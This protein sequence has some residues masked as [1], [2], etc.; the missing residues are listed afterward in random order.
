MK[1]ILYGIC[2]I[3][4]GHVFRQLPRILGYLENNATVAVLCYGRS[5]DVLYEYQARHKNLYLF[6]VEIPYIPG[7]S[8][9]LDFIGASALANPEG[10][11]INFEAMSKVSDLIG[12]PDIVFSDYEPFSAS[13]AYAYDSPLITIDQQSKYLFETCPETLNNT[14]YLDEVMRLR[15]FFPKAS[16]RIACSFFKIDR[17]AKYPEL[18]IV[19]APVRETLRHE[20]LIKPK[21]NNF[22][23]YLSE[24]YL[25]QDF[26]EKLGDTLSVH[27]NSIFHVY[28]PK[29]II[30]R[31]NTKNVNYFYHGD[32]S[33]ESRFL[34]SCGVIS[35]AGH[36]LLSECVYLHKPVL[37]IP[38]SIYEQQMNA[39]VIEHAGV[40]IR[41]NMI[42][43]DVITEFTT[44]INTF[45]KNYDGNDWFK[46]P[47]LSEEL[48]LGVI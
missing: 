43:S 35:T 7:S 39:F 33:F 42:N 15:L 37:A 36:S 21:E 4:N 14:S 46:V 38:L 40:G 45:R 22:L 48:I 20:K 29:S 11:K 13:Y 18:H 6:K 19:Q 2:G 1:K 5:F 44:Q 16:L 30:L 3:G 12:K 28:V 27:T 23:V 31:V 47:D 9:G 10:V 26:Y 41:A 8:S 32:P 34:Q 17:S 25:S 24:Q